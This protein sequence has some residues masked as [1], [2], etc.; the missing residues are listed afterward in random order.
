LLVK[1][2]FLPLGEL[3]GGVIAIINGEM[4]ASET[5]DCAIIGGVGSVAIIDAV[6]G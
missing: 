3:I 2:E 5:I 1:K 6:A 4:I